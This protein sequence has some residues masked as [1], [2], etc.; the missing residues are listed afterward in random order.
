MKPI[1]LILSI[2]SSFSI[3]GQIVTKEFFQIQTSEKN[4][5][6]IIFHKQS[7]DLNESFLITALNKSSN[8][9]TSC[10]WEVKLSIGCLKEL[11]QVLSE[12]NFDDNSQILYKNLS[13][14]VKKGRVRITFFN[15]S[16]LNEHSI[17]YF[18]KSC[19]RELSF[20]IKPDQI[21]SF[22]QIFDDKFL[23][24]IAVK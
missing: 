21:N 15:S 3:F 6:T 4:E 24:T 1:L 10:T 14:K 16:C 19:K 8:D 9:F 7:I 18:Q 23:N 5:K 20:P 11:Y 13:V 17:S 22:V 2:F 12:I